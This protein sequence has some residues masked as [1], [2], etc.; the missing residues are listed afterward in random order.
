MIEGAWGL[1]GNEVSRECCWNV[2]SII[3][4][5]PNIYSLHHQLSITRTGVSVSIVLSLHTK[6]ARTHTKVRDVGGRG[7]SHHAD[8]IP[9]LPTVVG[10]PRASMAV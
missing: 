6:L 8:R 1:K 4:G 2:S 9:N 5:E 7:L 10:L 3:I